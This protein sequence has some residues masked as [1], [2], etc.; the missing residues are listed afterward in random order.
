MAQGGDPLGTGF[1]GPAY[2]FVNEIAGLH[3]DPGTL[4]YANADADTNGSQFFITETA[5]LGLDTGYTIFGTCTPLDVVPKLTGVPRNSK[6]KPLTP[7]HMKTVTITR[8]A[9]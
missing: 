6:D 9:P 3:H 8:C 1:G 7:L 2:Q 4:S 5:Q